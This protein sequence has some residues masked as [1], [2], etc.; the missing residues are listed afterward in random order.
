[1]S[2][3]VREKQ[4]HRVEPVEVP[5]SAFDHRTATISTGGDT[6]QPPLVRKYQDSLVAASATNMARF[7]AL[8]RATGSPF[9][10][11]QRGSDL[12]R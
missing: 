1:M 4:S 7:P 8:D 10:T 2:A 3:N 6:K 9:T 5:R 11:D 12:H